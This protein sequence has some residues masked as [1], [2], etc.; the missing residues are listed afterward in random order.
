MANDNAWFVTPRCHAT[1]PPRLR[2]ALPCH[3]A[4]PSPTPSPAMASLACATTPRSFAAAPYATPRRY[5]RRLRHVARRAARPRPASHAATQ[6]RRHM[7]RA[8]ANSAT[9]CFHA[10]AATHVVM[11][12]PGR[13]SSRCRHLLRPSSPSPVTFT[14]SPPFTPTILPRPVVPSRRSPRFQNADSI[15]ML[16]FR[17][18]RLFSARRSRRYRRLSPSSFTPRRLILPLLSRPSTPNQQEHG[19]KARG[20]A[21]GAYTLPR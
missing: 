8:Y 4:T 15:F 9:P 12:P 5:A 18:P 21:Y 6:R 2:E 3:A 10:V 16:S 14:P 17:R 19:A 7:P 13:R 20:H 11:P 1:S